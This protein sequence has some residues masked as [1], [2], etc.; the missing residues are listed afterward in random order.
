M[1]RGRSSTTEH[2]LE[3]LLREGPLT[4][5]DIQQ[6]LGLSSSA[7][8]LHLD[9]LYREGLVTTEN[10]RQGVGR[11][12]KVYK[13]TPKA[14]MAIGEETDDLAVNILREVVELEGTEKARQIL[15][16]VSSRLARKYKYQLRSTHLWH[17]VQELQE[18]L[19][20]RGVVADVQQGE[21]RI[22]I[23]EYTCPY[24]DVAREHRL[25]CEMEESFLR[26]VLEAPVSLHDCMVDGAHKCVFEIKTVDG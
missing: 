12:V 13:L 11:P 4:V 22:Y 17:R 25:I 20:K 14:R 1:A 10:R 9:T 26:E 18:L 19:R 3:L 21:D 15:N 2:V 6:A 8:R 24:H 5:K 16:R 7:V 23:Y